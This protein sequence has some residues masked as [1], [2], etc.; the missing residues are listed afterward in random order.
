MNDMA[1][2]D[3]L[4]KTVRQALANALGNRP[5][6]VVREWQKQGV[7]AKFLVQHIRDWDKRDN[8]GIARVGLGLI[9]EQFEVVFT[10]R[11]LRRYYGRRATDRFRLRADP[12]ATGPDAPG[13]AA[14]ATPAGGTRSEP[15][16][17]GQP[18]RQ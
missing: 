1:I 12:A 5:V 8:A 14:A 7:K 6:S 11:N 13:A 3:R 2:F 15:D 16:A 17:A 10:R 18:C 4:P 9:R